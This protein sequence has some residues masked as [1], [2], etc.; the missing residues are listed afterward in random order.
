MHINIQRAKKVLGRYKY[1]EQSGND[2]S[3]RM[4]AVHHQQQQ[5]NSQGSGKN[6]TH[7][8]YMPT[9]CADIHLNLSAGKMPTQLGVLQV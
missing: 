4:T 5:Y 3:F 1:K 7:E 6:N 2:V 9:N 8:L